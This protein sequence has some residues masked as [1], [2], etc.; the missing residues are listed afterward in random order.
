LATAAAV[1]AEGGDVGARGE[2]GAEDGGREAHGCC[3]VVGRGRR[4]ECPRR[5][6]M[7]I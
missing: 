6:W 7:W 2:D 3:L 5:M 4:L 1:D